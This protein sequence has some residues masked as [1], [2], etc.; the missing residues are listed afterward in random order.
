[1]S[2]RRAP[3]EQAG[4]PDPVVFG[5]VP[6]QPDPP[7]P[8]P[9]RRRHRAG[10]VEISVN[11]DLRKLPEDLRKG[12]IA[13][14]VIRLARELDAGIVMGRDAAGHAREI[15]LSVLTLR[16]LAPA[17]EK[18]DQTDEVRARRER[19]LSQEEAG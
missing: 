1:M 2:L 6:P 4:P 13:A 11:R 19:R 8:P 18:G 9:V 5:P 17:G 15:R 3:Q 14:S 7:V 16:E 10:P 12:A